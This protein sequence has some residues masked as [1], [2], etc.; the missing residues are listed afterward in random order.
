MV[1][2][3][4]EG[5]K[6]SAREW[7]MAEGRKYAF[8]RNCQVKARSGPVR[9]RLDRLGYSPLT[10]R[11]P[12]LSH[13]RGLI[14]LCNNEPL[15]RRQERPP[16][17]YV[18]PSA[19]IYHTHDTHGLGSKDNAVANDRKRHAIRAVLKAA[20]NACDEGFAIPNADVARA[21]GGNE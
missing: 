1:I 18:A 9:K 21:V 4:I 2:E 19:S 12:L 20:R 7:E 15:G 3:G 13:T 5:V 6:G 17:H 10:T 16:A 8:E 14:V 11:L